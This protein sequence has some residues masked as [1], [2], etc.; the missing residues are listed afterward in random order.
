MKPTLGEDV[1]SL[2]AIASGAVI[3]AGLTAALLTGRP[4]PR[5][6]RIEVLEPSMHLHFDHLHQPVQIMSGPEGSQ[7]HWFPTRP[8]YELDP[9]DY[10]LIRDKTAPPRGAGRRSGEP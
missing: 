10:G 2:L 1:T 8:L 3:G 9:R 7:S 4:A 5:V 6:V